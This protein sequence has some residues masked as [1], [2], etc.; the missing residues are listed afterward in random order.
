MA[1]VAFVPSSGTS[2]QLGD[3]V[4]WGDI[5]TLLLALLVCLIQILGRVIVGSWLTG[6]VR[7]ELSAGE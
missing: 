7:L 1:A 3:A 4:S 6:M 2:V 5:P